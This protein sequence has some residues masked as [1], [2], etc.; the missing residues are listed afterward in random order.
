MNKFNK[1]YDSILSEMKGTKGLLNSLGR[2]K[3]LKKVCDKCGMMMPKYSGKYP[4]KCPS[5]GDPIDYNDK[6][7]VTGDDEFEIKESISVSSD[8]KKKIIAIA[9]GDTGRD[10]DD[11]KGIQDDINKLLGKKYKA[12]E[13]SKLIDSLIK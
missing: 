5:C 2:N 11:W 13:L 6:E 10:A 4:E 8:Q 9:N 1:Q 7:L 12:D 3:E